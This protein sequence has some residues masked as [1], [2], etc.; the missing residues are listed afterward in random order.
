MRPRRVFLLIGCGLV[1]F[2]SIV[3]ALVGYS[4]QSV[5][6]QPITNPGNTTS[7]A[8]YNSQQFQLT[9][10]DYVLAALFLVAFIILMLAFRLTP[11]SITLAS[12]WVRPMAWFLVA[13]SLVLATVVLLMLPSLIYVDCGQLSFDQCAKLSG[14]SMLLIGVIAA[15][16]IVNLAFAAFLPAPL[17]SETKG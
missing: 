7:C 6:C 10:H 15:I 12:D 1:G 17:K 2:F 11:D 14:Q 9:I 4:A 8:Q 13:E 16:L 3:F 5:N